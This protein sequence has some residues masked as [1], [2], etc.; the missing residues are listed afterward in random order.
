MVVMQV[1]Q[2][3]GGDLGRG[4]GICSSLASGSISCEA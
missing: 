2:V 1:V 3:E 4:C